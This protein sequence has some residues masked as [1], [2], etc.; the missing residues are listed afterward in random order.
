MAVTVIK[1]EPYNEEEDIEQYFEKLEMFLLANGVKDDKKV[2]HVLSGIGAKAYAILRNLL[3]PH[4][5]RDG[6]LLW[7][8]FVAVF[9]PVY[10]VGVDIGKLF[11]I[12]WCDTWFCFQLFGPYYW[13]ASRL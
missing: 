13:L 2:G 5:I 12:R 3:A 4:V 11:S 1:F 10:S 9:S 7:L 6:G 8:A